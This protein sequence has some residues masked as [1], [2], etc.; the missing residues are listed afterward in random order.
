MT[1]SMRSWMLVFVV[2]ALVAAACGGDDD[3]DGGASED[4]ATE[5]AEDDAGEEPADDPSPGEGSDD[6]DDAAMGDE[7]RAPTLEALEGEPVSMG[8]AGNGGL[9]PAGDTADAEGS[10]TFTDVAGDP[11][12]G[13]TYA[14]QPAPRYAQALELWQAATPE[15]PATMMES[16]LWPARPQGTPGVALLDVDNDGDLDIYVTNAAGTANS[17]FVNQLADSGTM[18][19]VDNAV[20]AG[21]DLTAEE[22]HGV[23]AG[24]VEDDG[25]TDIFVTSHG[26]PN[27]LLRNNGDGT[28]AVSPG[29]PQAP[30]L[31]GSSC[32]MGDVNGDG[33]LDIAVGHAWDFSNALALVAI[34]FEQNLPNELLVQQADGTFVDEAGARGM[35]DLAGVPDGA[36][37]ITWGLT[38]V[39]FDADGDLDIIQADDQGA[40]PS[41]KYDGVDRGY[42]Q[43]LTNDG[44]GTFTAIDAG[45]L[46]AGTWMGVSVADFDCNQT[47]DVFGSNFGDYGI[48]ALG[49]PYELGDY[50]TRW[51]LGDGGG[52]FDDP[53]VGDLGTTHFAWGGVSEDFDNDGDPDL[54]FQ[55]G[56]DLSLFVELSNP[57][58]YLVNEGCTADFALQQGAFDVNHQAREVTGTAAGDLDGDGFVDVVT[59]ANYVVPD[60]YPVFPLMTEYGLDTDGTGFFTSR[61]T[62]TEEGT[63]VYNG[64]EFAPGTLTVEINSGNGNAGL[65]VDAVGSAGI[66]AGARTSSTGIGAIVTVI[67]ADGTTFTKPVMGGT[68]YLSSDS[69]TI[70]AGLGNGSTATVEI[71]WPGGTRNR[72]YDV[73][74]GSFVAPEIPCSY[75]NTEKSVTEY[76]SCVSGALADLADAGVI[77]DATSD[78]LLEDAL[79]AREEG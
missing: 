8:D 46:T 18:S 39:D 77:D 59:V 65:S 31:G 67:G 5:S 1:L 75:D 20:A 29:T 52:K 41:S 60:E 28:F 19:F 33:L 66:T 48:P 30:S 61:F 76:T 25:D 11:A 54:V 72:Y 42:L 47:L 6:G 68:G 74:A 45:T 79:R 64:V 71:L 38:M 70:H 24:D 14:R 56:L 16:A 37:T 3:P 49:E 21:A 32:A 27:R 4:A 43:V 78:R 22:G 34:P 55:G 53:G 17:L 23:C 69:P 10:V 13:L 73:A 12:M 51:L 57:G 50:A 44:T 35:L 58:T 7:G 15:T 36:A 9:R 26:F 2:L 62:P 40:L 63:F